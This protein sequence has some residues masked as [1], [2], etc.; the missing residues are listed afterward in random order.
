MFGKYQ[1]NG[2]L[3][4]KNTKFTGSLTG[5]FIGDRTSTRASIRNPQRHIKP[6]FFTNLHLTYAPE[7]NQK[8]WLHLNNL[9]DR[10][11]ITSNSTANF[12]SLGRNFMLGYEYTF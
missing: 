10:I 5:N 12:Y 7:S 6:Q 8:V 9:L 2:G 11:D 3:N 4:Y 1:I